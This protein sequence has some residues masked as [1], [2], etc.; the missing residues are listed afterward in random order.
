[1][2]I[3]DNHVSTYIQKLAFFHINSDAHITFYNEIP[4]HHRKNRKMEKYKG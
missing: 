1:M 4:F 2:Y 3:N